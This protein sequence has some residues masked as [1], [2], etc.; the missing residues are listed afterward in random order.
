[1]NP[2]CAPRGISLAHRFD[3][4]PDLRRDH[5]PTGSSS[6]ALPPPVEAEAL[7]VPAKDGLWLD[8]DNG[9]TPSGPPVRETDP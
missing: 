2:R 5:W 3:E 7:P 1:V 4:L 6:W 8:D 9:S